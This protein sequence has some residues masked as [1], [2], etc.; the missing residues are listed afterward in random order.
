MRMPNPASLTALRPV[1]VAIVFLRLAAPSP[2]EESL[3]PDAAQWARIEKAM[4]AQASVKPLKSRRL[5]VFNRNLEYDGHRASILAC[6]EAFK[7]FGQKTGA[8]EVTISE[9]PALFDRESLRRFDAV[10]LNNTIGSCVAEPERR[11][12][13]LEFVTGGGGLM[14]VHGTSIAFTKWQ[15]WPLEDWPEFGH[16]IG[17]RGANHRGGYVQEPVVLALDDA[18]HPLLEAFGGKAHPWA[19]E[20]FRF[21]DPYSRRNVRVLLRID[22]EQ[23]DL[24]T[25]PPGDS[26]LRADNDYA[27]AWIRTY[28]KGRVFYSALAHSPHVFEDAAMLRFYLDGAQFVLGDLPAPTTPSAFLSPA[29]RAREKLGWR[30]GIEAYTFHKYTFFEAIEKTAELGLPAIGGLSFMQPVSKDIA[31]NFDQNLSDDELLRI[32]MKLESAGVQMP[33]YYAQTIPSDEAACRQLFEFGNKMGI[34]TFICEPTPEQLDL[35]ERLADEYA[36]NVG[37]H[38]HGPNISPH[39]WQ[40]EQVL[41]L[42]EGRGR[43]IGAAPDIGYWLRH[44]IDPIEAVRL[45]KDRILTVQMHDLHEPGGNGHDVPWGTGSGRS[46]ELLQELH[47]H[48]IKPTMIGLEY[49]YDWFESMP[50]LARC[51][52]FFDATTS[53][54][55]AQP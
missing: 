2:A 1:L 9:D 38:N 31:K 51:I 13:L 41:A 37:I 36:I 39:S 4:P 10:F 17:A 50:K 47:R 26:C 42:C 24:S 46:R 43:R 6:S 27:L 40:P 5:L 3:V 55:A 29:V 30:I 11:K 32:R 20:I 44:G 12:N 33:V 53:E 23:T 15:W 25:Y 21:H 16:M 18:D 34:E 35:L 45:L 19:D 28:G 22:T 7:R 49:S 14:G 8:F 52:E 54:L 48:G